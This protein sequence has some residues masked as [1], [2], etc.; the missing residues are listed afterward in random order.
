MDAVELRCMRVAARQHGTIS[1]AQAIDAGMS[2]DRVERRVKCGAWQRL[3]PAVFRVEG[4]PP[5]WKQRLKGAA[6]WAGEGHALSHGTAAALHGF[7]WFKGTDAI[8]LTTVKNL[9]V[10]G[11]STHHVGALHPRDL[12]SVECFRVTS[13]PRTL[14]DLSA[15]LP[16]NEVRRLADEAMRRKWMNV[17]RFEQLLERHGGS[18]GVK[19]LREFTSEYSGGDGPT[20]SVLEDLVREL[21]ER[22]GLPKPVKQRAVR[23]GRGVRRI[24]FHFPGTPVIIEADG[25]AWHASVDAF[26]RDRQRR[27]ELTLRG[28]QILQWTWSALNERPEEL[29]VELCTLLG[30]YTVAKRAA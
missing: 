2:E 5:S 3:F 20:E 24:D 6:L 17:D 25:Y 11:V 13:V 7:D 14:L 21:L 15:V 10:P 23:V 26:E 30:Q 1:R 19:L 9:R 27:N 28:F 4:A 8:E 18:P 12:A 29:L 22:A 16:A